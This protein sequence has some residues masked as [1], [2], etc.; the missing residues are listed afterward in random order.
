MHCRNNYILADSFKASG[1]EVGLSGAHN[2]QRLQKETEK[3]GVIPWGMI[4][5]SHDIHYDPYC[6]EAIRLRSYLAIAYGVKG[7]LY[8]TGFSWHVAGS[9]LYRGESFIDEK[10][11]PTEFYN[12]V[13]LK[14]GYKVKRLGNLFMSLKTGKDIASSSDP[15]ATVTT[16]TN[17]ED[18]YIFVVN[19]DL[20]LE[21]KVPVVIEKSQFQKPPKLIDMMTDETISSE[22]KDYTYTINVDAA[23]M[24]VFKMKE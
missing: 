24:R 22:K 3:A 21:R 8:F 16:R 20:D 14:V 23:E 15:M 17:E 4:H 13:A 1:S 10:A 2:V 11:N 12:E 18:I 5:I 9:S 7:I 6:P 19:E